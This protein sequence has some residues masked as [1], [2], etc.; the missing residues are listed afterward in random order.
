[1]LQ[2]LIAEPLL[3]SG[4]VDPCCSCSNNESLS[5]RVQNILGS[6]RVQWTCKGRGYIW[7]IH[8]VNP[9]KNMNLPFVKLLSNGT[10]WKERFGNAILSLDKFLCFL[11]IWILQP[12]VGVW[13]GCTK[14]IIHNTVIPSNRRVGPLA[15]RSHF[16]GCRTRLRVDTW[17]ALISAH[18]QS[19][20]VML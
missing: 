6:H 3:T 9:Y 13:Y 8:H 7:I 4:F 17:V 15:R 20:S 19:Q 5:C 16:Y 2:A 11:A 18:A 14:V 10:R 1:M 12:L